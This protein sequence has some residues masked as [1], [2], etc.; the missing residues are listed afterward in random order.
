MDFKRILIKKS[1]FNVILFSIGHFSRENNV[2][3]WFSLFQGEKNQMVIYLF[4][5]TLNMSL[6]FLKRGISLGKRELG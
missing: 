4:I 1:H 2:V 3:A 6:L 5:F